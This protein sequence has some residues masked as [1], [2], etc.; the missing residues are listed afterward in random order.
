MASQNPSLFMNIYRSSAST[1]VAS[2]WPE[3]EDCMKA[4]YGIQDDCE[5]FPEWQRKIEEEL[6]GTMS[7]LALQMD[8]ISRDIACETSETFRRFDMEKQ[9]YFK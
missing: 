5:G 9:K 1:T 2:L 6:G 7:F 3:I 4:Y 8:E